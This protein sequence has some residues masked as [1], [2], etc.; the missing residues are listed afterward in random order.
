[1]RILF[2]AALVASLVAASACGQG[3]AFDNGLRD[4]FRERALRSCLANARATAPAGLVVDL[5]RVCSC[6]VD[7][8]MEGKSGTELMREND[9]TDLSGAE[10]A[11][12]QCVNA[13]LRRTGRAPSPNAAARAAEAG[14]AGPTE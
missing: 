7:R 2:V 14:A 11:M 9:N 3:S 8:H 1:M 13:E 4:S 5:D 12:T 6:W 10:A